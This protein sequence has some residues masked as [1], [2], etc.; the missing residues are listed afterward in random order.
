L[1]VEIDLN[2]PIMAGKEQR[3]GRSLFMLAASG[4]A[5]PAPT[6]ARIPCRWL[7]MI[8][9]SSNTTLGKRSG[10]AYHTSR[11]VSPAGFNIS[12]HRKRCRA[13]TTFCACR[14][15]RSRG[16][17]GSSRDGTGVAA[18]GL[19]GR[20]L[21][22]WLYKHIIYMGYPQTPERTGQAPPLQVDDGVPLRGGRT[23]V[24]SGGRFDRE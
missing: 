10:N 9:N 18:C 15:L 12:A 14:L 24:G 6:K 1:I 7:G 13:G 21:P 17:L 2:A 22:A 16:L 11:A 23:G 4:G 20:M 8:M 19:V 5:S 3:L